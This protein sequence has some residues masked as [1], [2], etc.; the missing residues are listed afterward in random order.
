MFI[1]RSGNETSIDMENAQLSCSNI[2]GLQLT[3]MRQWHG[4]QIRVL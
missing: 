1:M 2:E 4:G 3:A